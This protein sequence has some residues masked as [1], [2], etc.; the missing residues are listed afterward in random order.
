[1]IKY[2]VLSCVFL[3]TSL[4]I[5]WTVLRGDDENVNVDITYQHQ[6]NASQPSS[7]INEGYHARGYHSSDREWFPD[8]H[9]YG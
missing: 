7:D 4:C 8:V 3:C 6:L 2:D 1:M 5:L 9:L